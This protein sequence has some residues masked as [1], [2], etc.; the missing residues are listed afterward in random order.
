[1]TFQVRRGSK[2]IVIHPGSRYLRIGRACDVT[3]VTVPNAIARKHKLPVPE[4]RFIEG[5]S[6]P[7]QGNARPASNAATTG[8][9]Y[10]VPIISDDPVRVSKL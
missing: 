8:D 4:P 10:A 1:M 3:P 2:V 7:K 9:E 5:I 6:R